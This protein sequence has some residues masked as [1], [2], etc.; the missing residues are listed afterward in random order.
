MSVPLFTWLKFWLP[1]TTLYLCRWIK[2]LL[3]HFIFHEVTRVLYGNKAVIYE[4]NLLLF[5]FHNTFQKEKIVFL[6]NG[7]IL[8]S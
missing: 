6:H 4:V 1:T 3:V 5:L 2:G 8:A 7:I